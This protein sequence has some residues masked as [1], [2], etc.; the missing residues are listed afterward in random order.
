MAGRM[1]SRR[2]RRQGPVARLASGQRFEGLPVAEIRRR[3]VRLARP[4][5]RGGDV[6]TDRWVEVGRVHRV[7]GSEI[8]D[9]TTSARVAATA[10]EHLAALE[11]ADQDQAIG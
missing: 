4:A 1:E 6:S 5:R 11:P 8:E 3:A 7:A 10:A 9:A 2:R